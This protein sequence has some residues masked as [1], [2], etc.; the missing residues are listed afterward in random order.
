MPGMSP[1]PFSISLRTRVSMGSSRAFCSAPATAP[2][3]CEMLMPLSLSTTVM[4]D[5]RC[6]AW[7]NASYAM[8]PV[9]AP[10]PITATMR[11]SR[12]P[13]TRMASARPTAYEM[14]VLAWPAPITSCSLSSRR[15]KPDM[16]SY[17]R[18]V[19]NWPRRPVSSLW[20]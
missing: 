14:L 7:F 1:R 3:F 10:S 2:T 9:M 12:R 5:S 19:G 13:L 6:P 18:S 11:R 17:C 15:R 8:P 4:G 20:P 16:P